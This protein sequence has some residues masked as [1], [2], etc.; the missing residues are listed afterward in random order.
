MT[1]AHSPWRGSAANYICLVTISTT[2]ATTTMTIASKQTIDGSLDRARDVTIATMPGLRRFVINFPAEGTGPG[3]TRDT[4]AF[5]YMTH[6]IRRRL[7][8]SKVTF[9]GRVL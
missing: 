3:T 8:V 1:V 7:A 5:D 4:V 2:T 9:G 6:A